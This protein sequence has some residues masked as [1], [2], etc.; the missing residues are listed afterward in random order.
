MAMAAP[1]APLF[2]RIVEAGGIARLLPIDAL[3]T[4]LPELAEGGQ[5]RG[6]DHRCLQAITGA[7]SGRVCASKIEEVLLGVAHDSVFAH[8]LAHLAHHHAPTEMCDRIDA[9]YERAT[10]VD[11][12]SPAGRA[13]RKP[14]SNATTVRTFSAP[15]T[16][17]K[18]A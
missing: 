14:P 17:W 16:G 10:S 7:A 3:L 6:D 4:D 13:P 2:P 8:E 15:A 9:L 5:E 18:A 1:L 12:R 11:R